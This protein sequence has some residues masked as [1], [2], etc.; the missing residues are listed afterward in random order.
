[1][2]IWPGEYPFLIDSNRWRKAN[3]SR[4]ESIRVVI[5]TKHHDGFALWD[6]KVSQSAIPHRYE[7]GEE[8]TPV[9]PGDFRR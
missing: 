8:V 1:M 7:D 9:K 5:T 6:S 2:Q 3:I 4:P